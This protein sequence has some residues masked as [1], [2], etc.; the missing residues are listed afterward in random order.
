[1]AAVLHHSRAKGTAKL[2]LLG[3]A[4][5]D[6]DG[7]AYPAVSTL[8][9]YANTHERT[10][11]RAIDQLVARGELRRELQAGG[12][13]EMPDHD[14][15]NRYHVLVSCPP[16]CDRTS[17]HR[18]TRERRQPGL[19]TKGVASTP[20][21][22]ASATP[23]RRQCHPPGGRPRHP[24]HPPNLTPLAWVQHHRG[25]SGAVSVDGLAVPGV[26]W[27]RPRSA[28][29]TG[30]ATSPTAGGCHEPRRVGGPSCTAVGGCGAGRVR[31]RLPPV[32]PRRGRQRGPPHPTNP[33]AP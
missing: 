9:R 32:P 25:P 10:V 21:G 4:N 27:P 11:Q 3:I 8:A 18:D 5:H 22:G 29:R 14:R 26:S 30:T 23:P 13:R 16:W 7:G 12:S 17:Q 31:N 15:P 6:G 19:W 24:N 33:A 2:V 20:P 1:M 28:H